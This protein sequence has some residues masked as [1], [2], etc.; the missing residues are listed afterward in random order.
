ML[1]LDKT[2]AVWYKEER[3][4]PPLENTYSPFSPQSLYCAEQILGGYHFAP[5]GQEL[6]GLMNPNCRPLASVSWDNVFGSALSLGHFLCWFLDPMSRWHLLK[7]RQ[8]LGL[9]VGRCKMGGFYLWEFSKIKETKL[10]GQTLSICKN[11]PNISSDDP[12]S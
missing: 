6:R 5:L 7:A 12:K 8:Y 3:W 10:T 9:L 4:K 2:I 11:H 1:G